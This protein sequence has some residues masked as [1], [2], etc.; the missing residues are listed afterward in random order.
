MF[1]VTKPGGI[2]VVATLGIIS[3]TITI[4]GITMMTVTEATG[5]R[6]RIGK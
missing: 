3:I 6:D 5:G 2:I 1:R 4:G